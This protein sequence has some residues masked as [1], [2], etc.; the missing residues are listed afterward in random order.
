MGDEASCNN[1]AAALEMPYGGS[2]SDGGAPSGC[3]YL[4]ADDGRVATVY[5][6]TH[7]EATYDD[8]ANVCQDAV[9]EYHAMSLNTHGCTGSTE[10]VVDEA[11]CSSAAAAL[12]MPYG[13]SAS[14][15]GAPSG[16]YYL[17]ADDDGRVGTVYWNTHVERTY[18]DAA[19]VC[20][21]VPA[22]SAWQVMYW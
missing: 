19:S 18:D 20:Q 12:E 16:C 14:D 10:A 3:Y 11:S 5:W 6:N 13:G 9:A 1:A 8:A 7:A 4:A 2:A 15:G 17:V 22:T 21:A